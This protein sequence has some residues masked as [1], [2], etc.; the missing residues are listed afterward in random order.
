[1]I[2][3]V[4]YSFTRPDGGTTNSLIKPDCEYTERVRII[5]EEGMAIT[6]D[7]ENLYTVIDADTAE[8]FY[9]VDLLVEQEETETV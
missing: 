8:G 5:A 7:D 4:L 3:K 1:M 2:T 6:N 9:E